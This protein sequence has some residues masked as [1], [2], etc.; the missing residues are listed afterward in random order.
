MLARLQ[1][2]LVLGQLAL[3]AAWLAWASA[4]GLGTLITVLVATGLL[5]THG[6]ILALDFFLLSRVGPGAGMAPPSRSALLRA[7]VLEWRTAVQVFS[8][9]QPFRAERHADAVPAAG[10][11]VGQPSLLLVHGFFCNRAIW[12][13]WLERL[14]AMGVPHVAV[15]L[16]PVFGSIDDYVAIVAQAHD[17]LLA[18]TG[19]A[20]LVVAHSMGGVAVRAWLAQRRPAALP[21]VITL[22]APHHGTWIARFGLAPNNRQM[23]LNSRWLQAL[24]Q[25]ETAATYLAFT[26]WYSDCDNIVF[27]AR[28]AMLAGADNRFLPGIG[29]VDLIYHPDVW[30][31]VQRRLMAPPRPS[32]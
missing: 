15:N 16:E 6:A 4:L 12:N 32:M 7:W 8:W 2:L 3:L 31:D 27:P 17:R 1:R 9:R 13:P 11:A 10:A 18:A 24:A 30:A 5:C 22:G 29:H 26:C 19:R 25:R 28:T 23:R 14:R 21:Q 20:P